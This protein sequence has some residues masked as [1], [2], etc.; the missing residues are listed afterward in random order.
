MG[1]RLASQEA[2]HA[3][4]SALFATRRYHR[5]GFRQTPCRGRPNI[6]ARYSRRVV[7]RAGGRGQRAIDQPDYRGGFQVG[8]AAWQRRQS[9]M[10]NQKPVKRTIEIE[11]IT[12]RYL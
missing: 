4:P 7:P 12:N 5:A 1:V 8:R 3:S 9:G 6:T 2:D 11:E 10:D